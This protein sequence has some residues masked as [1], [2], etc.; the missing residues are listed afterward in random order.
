MNFL[1]NQTCSK[2]ED[3]MYE[4]LN[5]KNMFSIASLRENVDLQNMLRLPS[6]EAHKLKKCLSNYP[7]VN[8]EYTARPIAQT[9]LKITVTVIPNFVYSKQF[10]MPK[11]NFWLIVEDMGEML[12]YESLGIVTKNLVHLKAGL[13]NPVETSFFVPFR[14]NSGYYGLHVVSDRFVDADSY[15]E[16]DLSEIE[17]HTERMEYTN[18][19]NLRPLPISVLNNPKFEELYN[20]IKFFNPIQ[21]QIFHS[22]FH[23]DENILIG[24][25]TGSGKTIMAELAILRIFNTTKN[26]KVIYI[27]PYK[28]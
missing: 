22:L 21:T 19:L 4:D 10:H 2:I 14:E 11:E 9:I 8:I 6:G 18:L 24:A 5:G 20:K 13:D 3:Q 23:S 1:D 25:P 17:V 7:L 28:A 16:I 15:A 26:E 12:H 27:A